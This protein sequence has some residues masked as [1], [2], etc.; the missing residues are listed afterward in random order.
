VK[1]G[2]TWL[3]LGCFWFGLCADDSLI[4][5]WDFKTGEFPEVF[6]GA[7]RGGTARTGAGLESGESADKPGGW[8]MSANHP[9][10]TPGGAFSLE[11]EFILADNIQKPR[12]LLWDSKYILAPKADSKDKR[13]HSGF[14]LALNRRG[15]SWQPA[16]YFGY[17]ESSLSV[18][19]KPEKL[20]P[21]KPYRLKL[22][23]SPVEVRFF[24]NGVLNA[25]IPLAAPGAL[26]PAVYRTVI[27]DRVGS[28]YMGW[29]GTVTG[30]ELRNM[31]QRAVAI[32]PAG[33]MVFVRLENNPEL[34]LQIVNVSG[35][36]LENATVTAQLAGLPELKIPSRNLNL[37]T[38][39]STVLSF[40]LDS[41]LKPGE[42]QLEVKAA[43]E[44]ASL[45]LRV[46]A[47]N[48]DEYPVVMWGVGDNRKLKALGFTHQLSG[49]ANTNPDPDDLGKT[50]AG[51][52]R[53][54]AALSEGMYLMDN[55]SVYRSIMKDFP[56][57]TR[58]GKSYP[59]LNMEASNPETGKRLTAIAENTSKA[60]GSHPGYSGALI[61]SEVR[62]GSNPSFNQF[63][64]D[65]YKKFS[66]REVPAVVNGRNPPPYD[67]IAG[68]PVTRIIPQD[69]SLLQYYGWWWRVG[70][71]WNPLHG[72]ISRALHKHARPGFWTFY[73]P[74]VRVPPLWGS[75]GDV[76]CIS[77]WS[78]TNPDPIKIGQS[79][80]EMLAMHG[81]NPK[82][83]VMKMTQVFWYRNQS[84][85]TGRKPEQP[86]E[87][88]ATEPEAKYISI[89][90]DH[91]KIALWSKISRKLDGIMYHGYS[92]LIEVPGNKHAYRFTNPACG[93]ALTDLT[94]EVIRP[95]GAL[96]KRIPERRP[97]VAVLQ[98]FASTI[99]AQRHAS[100]GWGRGWAAD[101]HLA[102]QW[103]HLQPSIIYDEHILNGILDQV[104]VLVLPG[105]EVLTEPVFQAIREFQRKGGFVI[106][107]TFTVP[108]I[109][110]DIQ[111]APVVRRT[112]DPVGTK[113]DLQRFGA[114]IRQQLAAYYRPPF[115]ADD[116]DLVL[117]LRSAGN[118]DYLFAVN[119]KLAFGDYIGQWGVVQETGV[120]LSG[121]IT[122]NRTAGA[123]YDLVKHQPVKFTSNDNQCTIPVE[124]EP[125][126]GRLL[127]IL[128][129]PLTKMEI[130]APTGAKLG[131]P[132][133]VTVQTDNVLIP[134]EWQLLNPDG[135]PAPGSGWFCAE[136][137]VL[138]R[139]MTPSLNEKSGTWKI[140]VKNLADGKTVTRDIHIQ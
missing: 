118:V 122:L 70:D 79:T 52:Q 15:D 19:G 110:P 81:G 93:A 99:F 97:E 78:Y 82:Q 121:N 89:S 66:G 75:G 18:S 139:Q 119:D 35:K 9:E 124:L 45:P 113:R 44:T 100:Y 109:L 25:E 130:S 10:L 5:R 134:L 94:R 107:D 38:G 84:A 63:E 140:V 104:D 26:A 73:D 123:V 3:L 56:R 112:A 136:N 39:T 88:L 116:A 127:M 129:Q 20:E 23:Y 65:A 76:D 87:W 7:P 40:P 22:E 32:S 14:A 85:P 29:M 49:F 133:E 96:L 61:Q 95:L 114:S 2:M 37:S 42:Y 24:L 6:A 13:H 67:K 41:R 138:K 33:R 125:G 43:D 137:G 57:V 34:A 91:L 71:G 120:P 106:G 115:A 50:L 108:G 8:M 21:G 98:S 90:P 92:S 30:A 135:E 62:D 31:R 83:M 55:F 28:N 68:F 12:L 60:Y 54:D 132:F 103:A 36:A 1:Y 59:R 86:P 51:M 53:L 11:L 101:C 131:Q 126:G 111:M 105:V 27:G 4:A 77:Q 47:E 69:D 46:I 117:R 16:A 48:V 128:D 64:P 102:L 80:D 72:A 17:G 58:D 74:A